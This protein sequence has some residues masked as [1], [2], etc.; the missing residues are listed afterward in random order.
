MTDGLHASL[1]CAICGSTAVARHCLKPPATYYRCRSCSFIFQHPPPSKAD[2]HAYADTEYK[3]GGL[4]D[5]YVRARTMK[6]EHF[7]RRLAGIAPQL[8][9]RGRLLDVGCS[10]GYFM[11]V[12]AEAGYEVHGL[13]FSEHAIAAAAPHIRPL[14]VQAT[15]D[16]VARDR[17]ASYDV[18]S[19]FDIIEHLETPLEFLGQA[20]R[21]LTPQGR[22]VLSTP[23]VS[24]WLRP[25]M[26]ARWPMLQPMQHLSLFSREALR[27]ALT[28]A[29]FRP[30]VL[31]PA[32]KVLSFE[33]LIGQLSTL[34][35][36]IHTTLGAATRLVPSRTMQ[37]WRA[38]NI[39]EVLAIAAKVD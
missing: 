27:I 21:L 14:I 23:D 4:Y 12:A 28:N 2:I 7:R 3:A 34:N 29:G 25:V 5:E 38:I 37:A 36:L 8:P 24:H 33:Y 35:P 19:A 31:G 10:C 22:L 17:A 20:R 1:T 30:L 39:G 6:I 32:H 9:S 18:I 11:E 15:V 26:G 13:E 16:D